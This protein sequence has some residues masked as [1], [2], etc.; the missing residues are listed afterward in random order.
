MKYTK[1]FFKYTVLSLLFIIMLLSFILAVAVGLAAILG[2]CFDT[3]VQY[4]VLIPVVLFLVFMG[5]VAID[6]IE[7]LYDK[8]NI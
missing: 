4:L 1:K 5:F 2:L 6:C 8:W 3:K 7:D